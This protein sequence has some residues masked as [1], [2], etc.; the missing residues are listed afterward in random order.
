MPWQKKIYDLA[1]EAGM[2]PF[3][4]PKPD[5]IERGI[6][7]AS[8]GSQPRGIRFLRLL[9]EFLSVESVSV[10]ELAGDLYPYLGKGIPQGIM[11]LL[12]MPG[13]E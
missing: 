10:S 9:P 1:V 6:L 7:K 2:S 4:A 5:K 12:G 3:K 13:S 8:A 11:I